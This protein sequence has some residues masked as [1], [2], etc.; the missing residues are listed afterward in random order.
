[1]EAPAPARVVAGFAA[2]YLVWGSTFL[3]IAWAVETIPPF[4][5]MAIRCLLGGSILFL[6]ARALPSARQWAGALVVGAFLFVGCHGLLAVAEQDVPSGMA[7]LCLATIPLMVPLLLWAAGQS[8][9]PSTR[10]ALALLAGFGGVALLV[11]SQGDVVGLSAGQAALL[12]FTAFGWAAGTVATRLVP[13]PAS[14]TV[15]AASALIAGG[16]LLV[17]VAIGAGERIDTGAVSGRSLFGLLYLVVM[18]TV[19]TFSAYMWLLRVQP[20]SRVATYAF[21]NPATAVLLG[22][23]LAGET[24]TAGTL[25]ATAV[26]IA[27][28]AVAVSDRQKG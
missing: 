8:G 18:G 24:L 17:I 7:A 11:V 16:L 13:V 27:A 2:I 1:M 12:L 15:A 3:A 25:V 23:S 21:V 10:L 9:P 6:F 28:V 26:I 19:V 20:P 22:W 14:P 5:M 4:S